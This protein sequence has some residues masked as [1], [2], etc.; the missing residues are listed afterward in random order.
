MAKLIA[1][2]AIVVGVLLFAYS[3]TLGIYTNEDEFQQKYTAIEGANRSEQ[4][5]KLRAEY[6]TNKFV[7]EDYALTLVILGVLLLIFFRNGCENLPLPKRKYY[8]LLIGF[9]A[10]IFTTVGYIVL[11]LVQMDRQ[12]FPSWGDSI[13]IPLMAVPYI[14]LIGIIWASLNYLG[15]LRGFTEN[16]TI[17]SINLKDFLSYYGILAIIFVLL[18]IQSLIY[19]SFCDILGMVTWA[20]FYIAL[21]VGTKNIA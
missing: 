16:R 10:A 2:L 6:A 21:L 1:V 12:E 5:F 11:L 15:V 17:R 13:G 7:M 20:Y 8:I 14:F 9:L 18:S 4:F 3:T 19:G